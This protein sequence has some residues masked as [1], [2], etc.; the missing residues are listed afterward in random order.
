MC[1]KFMNF[2]C[3]NF[4][5]SRHVDSLNSTSSFTCLQISRKKT[6][7]TNDL[8]QAERST[9]KCKQKLWKLF[10]LSQ[11]LNWLRDHLNFRS[12]F[13]YL[14]LRSNPWNLI[15]FHF[16]VDDEPSKECFLVF[17]KQTFT[18]AFFNIKWRLIVIRKT[19]MK[20]F[21]KTWK[22][23]TMKKKKIWLKNPVDIENKT[24]KINLDSQ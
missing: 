19:S 9:E 1:S 12:S 21:K 11:F 5:L 3:F 24:L 7:P 16:I 22:T 4:H 17:R 18:W 20:Y 8:D 10:K 13:I 23:K 14:R 6:T 15:R 2:S